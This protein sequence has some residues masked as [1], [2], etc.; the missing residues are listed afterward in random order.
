M[1]DVRRP[2][3]AEKTLVQRGFRIDTETSEGTSINRGGVSVQCLAEKGLDF[4]RARRAPSEFRTV[5]ETNIDK[6][7][8][9]AGM[10]RDSDSDTLV[11][12]TMEEP[13]ECFE[14]RQG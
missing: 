8:I 14:L 4:L 10:R 1:A 2:N 11:D 9:A 6:A 3:I 5:G 7:L 12:T 13:C